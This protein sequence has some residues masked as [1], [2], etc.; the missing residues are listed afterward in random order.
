L[1]LQGNRFRSFFKK[2]NFSNTEPRQRLFCSPPFSVASVVKIPFTLSALETRRLALKLDRMK[3]SGVEIFDSELAQQIRREFKSYLDDGHSV[4]MAGQRIIETHGDDSV[5]VVYLVIAS[6]QIE[7]EVIQVKV[8]KKALTLIISGD[9]ADP[10]S[11]SAPEIFEKRKQ[12][13]QELR[14]RILDVPT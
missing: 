12:V 11:E 13:L 14:Q 2:H 9:A 6:L 1:G 5:M 8:K 4:Y 7:H 10:W 3:T